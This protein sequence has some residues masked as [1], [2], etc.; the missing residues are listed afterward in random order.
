MALLAGN[1][2]VITGGNG[3]IGLATA[4]RFVDEGASVFITGRRQAELDAA[5]Q[6]LGPAA[7]P[8]YLPLSRSYSLNLH[9]ILLCPSQPPR[10]SR[11]VGPPYSAH[12]SSPTQRGG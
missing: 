10:C 3:G 1:T 4:Q 11:Q 7:A 2:A 9:T 12:R 5:V 6:Q 8:G